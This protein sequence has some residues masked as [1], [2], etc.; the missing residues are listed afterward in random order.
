MSEQPQWFKDWLR[1]NP[2]AR[3]SLGTTFK[4]V[5]R[6]I[7]LPSNAGPGE[8]RI[9]IG[10]DL[11][12][13]LDT[14]VV[15]P[16]NRHF[17]A[18]IIFYSGTPS[19]DDYIFMAV[20]SPGALTAMYNGIVINGTVIERINGAG[21]P[22]GWVLETPGNTNDLFATFGLSDGTAGLGSGGLLIG[23]GS[24]A[25]NAL[26][27]PAAESSDFFL[28]N[29][30]ATALQTSSAV[31]VS[32]PQ[33]GNPT[34]EKVRLGSVG[35]DGSGIRVHLSG[36]LFIT[37]VAGTEVEFGVTVQRVGGAVIG[38]YPIGS[39]FVNPISTHTPFNIFADLQDIQFSPSGLRYEF[40]LLWRRASGSGVLNMNIDDSYA[41]RVE[42]Y[43]LV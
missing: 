35:F 1:D 17:V 18:A 3:A 30:S 6:S 7:T 25:R 22:A 21:F 15:Q 36:S 40:V 26:P 5:Q 43:M 9:V 12:P 28:G 31:F 20:A 42:E 11:P 13:P 37:G 4:R 34:M 38:N 14:Y 41:W 19:D 33:A 24:T 2:P 27:N 29:T 23:G 32:V 8:A 39:V 16:F 10:P